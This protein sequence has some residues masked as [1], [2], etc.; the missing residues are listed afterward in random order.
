MLAQSEIAHYLLSLGLV[1]PRAV[2]DDDFTVLDASRRN[3]V[4]L[5]GTTTG[6]TFV[7][8]QAGRRSAGTLAHEAGV[9][10]VLAA[11]DLADRVPAV[12]HHDPDAARLVLRTPGGARDWNEHHAAGRFSR[13]PARVLGRTLGALH[14]LPADGVEPLPAGFDRMWV[15]G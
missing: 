13:A 8:K 12:V 14:A 7:V 6:P 11:G 1:K 3:A 5:A 15:R 9:L 4:F 10:R 2:V